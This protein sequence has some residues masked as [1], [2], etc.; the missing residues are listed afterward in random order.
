MTY[1]AVEMGATKSVD[2]DEDSRNY[3][4]MRLRI[5]I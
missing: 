2:S 5:R 3:Q 1:P 4:W